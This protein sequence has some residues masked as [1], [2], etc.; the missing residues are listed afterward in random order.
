[1]DRG[2]E[3]AIRE[4]DKLAND[5]LMEQL[6][7]KINE[8][9]TGLVQKQEEDSR[10]LQEENLAIKKQMVELEREKLQQNSRMEELMQQNNRVMTAMLQK[11]GGVQPEA[12]ESPL[13]AEVTPVKNKTVVVVPGMPGTG[14][15]QVRTGEL[16][17]QWLPVRHPGEGQQAKQA[18]GSD[19]QEMA[20]LRRRSQ[21]MEAA[22]RDVMLMGEEGASMVTQLMLGKGHNEVVGIMT[23]GGALPSEAK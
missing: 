12:P 3:E 8:L 19:S 23:A 4:M 9:F 10:K 11:M 7:R 13:S 6:G 16:A 2:G 22:L 5:Q 21:A 17:Q 15:K 18:A 14:E 1:M 20:E